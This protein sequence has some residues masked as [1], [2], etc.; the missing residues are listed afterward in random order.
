MFT[1]MNMI[2]GFYI[3]FQCNPVSAA[4]D[5]DALEDGAKCNPAE[6][7]ADIYYATTAVNIFTDWATAFMPIPLLWNVQLSRN[8]KISVICV[9]SL[10][11]FA[12]I[13]ACVRLRYTVNL[14]AQENYLYA[15]ADIVIWGYAENG[16]GLIVGCTMTL[17]PLL[18]EILHLDG[19]TSNKMSN[20]TSG[21]RYGFGTNARRTNQHIT[22][23]DDDG[24]QP[25]ESRGHVSSSDTYGNG[26]TLTQISCTGRG[27]QEEDFSSHSF[28][29]E[30][31]KK[32]LFGDDDAGAGG[33]MVT[34]DF[35]LFR[36]D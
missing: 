35:K 16:M 26:I 24:A 31:Q 23:D 12:S 33:I 32:I 3:I 17:R 21:G 14:T 8:T 34:R 27:H 25:S 11:F 2:A 1:I 30:S 13:S 18:R 29:T 20:G 5:I 28:D 4:W 36:N 7:M 10:G 19:D 6:Y 22:I 9:L 15:L